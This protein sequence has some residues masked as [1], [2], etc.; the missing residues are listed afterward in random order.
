MTCLKCTVMWEVRAGRRVAKTPRASASP[1]AGA[2]AG[3][4]HCPGLCALGEE[5]PQGR[6]TRGS[7]GGSEALKAKLQG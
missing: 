7:A 2:S 1:P 5:G 3:L 6:G 4:R